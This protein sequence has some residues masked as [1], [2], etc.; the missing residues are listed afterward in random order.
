[1][2]CGGDCERY[3]QPS[4]G[5]G[6]S[7]NDETLFAAKALKLAGQHVLNLDDKLAFTVCVGND[8]HADCHAFVIKNRRANISTLCKR[9]KD[10]NGNDT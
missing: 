5:R 6:L 9:R 8:C 10:Q 2:R 7:S 4:T 3:Y 1:M